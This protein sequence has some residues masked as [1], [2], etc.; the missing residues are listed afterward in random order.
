VTHDLNDAFQLADRLFFLST[1]PA[2]II[3]EI[4]LP[5]P[6]GARNKEMIDRIAE[7]VR[8]RVPGYFPDSAGA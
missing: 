4:P 5:P 2:S 6:R 1:R 3:T 8:S 7:E